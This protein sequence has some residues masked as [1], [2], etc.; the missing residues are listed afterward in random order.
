MEQHRK[1]STMSKTG[2]DKHIY[3]LAKFE[4]TV[5]VPK[6]KKWK[7]SQN[8]MA[9][10]IRSLT[11]LKVDQSKVSQL[12]NG[13]YSPQKR[14][15]LWLYA[16]SYDVSTEQANGL[17]CSYENS[18]KMISSGILQTQS[19]SSSRFRCLFHVAQPSMTREGS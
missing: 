15:E 1:G 5:L 3:Q 17:L 11:A 16:G 4:R 19:F 7:L 14:C 8:E 9:D 10:R 12:E 18:V 6:C 13:I 2:L